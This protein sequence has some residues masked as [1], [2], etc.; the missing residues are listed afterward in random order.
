MCTVVVRWGASVEILALRDE[1]VGREFDDPGA[2]WPSQPSVVGGRDRVAGGSWCVTDTGSGVTALVL[3]RPQKR[4]GTPSRGALPLLAV[5]HGA[6]WPSYIDVTGMASFALVLAAPAAL[7]LWVWD[8]SSLTSEAL[9]P[10][11]HMVT[12]GGVEDGKAARYLGDFATA[13]VGEWPALVARHEPADDRAALVVRHAFEGGV[14]A[15]VFGQVITADE[16]GVQLSW[17]RTP[18]ELDSWS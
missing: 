11:T 10:G 15:T 8:G 9:V 18:W 1:L 5:E 16:A 4:V 2:W 7:T 6:D 12:S 17:S 14:Y 3:N 13:P